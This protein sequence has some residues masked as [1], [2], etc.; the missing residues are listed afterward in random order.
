MKVILSCNGEL[1]SLTMP[2]DLSICRKS[3]VSLACRSAHSRGRFCRRSKV[4]SDNFGSQY[5]NFA[6]DYFNSAL[7]FR[8]I[9][10]IIATNH[11]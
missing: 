8:G 1:P 6:S 2:P 9:N 4:N 5:F 3:A 11:P 10:A 7:S